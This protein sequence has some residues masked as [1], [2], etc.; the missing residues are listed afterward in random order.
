MQSTL[1][2]LAATLGPADMKLFV[3]AK[4]KLQTEGKKKPTFGEILAR[5]K[6]MKQFDK[7]GSAEKDKD[8]ED[9]ES[10]K[11]KPMLY[12]DEKSDKPE[13]ATVSPN[14]GPGF[15][16]R[17][18]IP[19]KAASLLAPLPLLPQSTA[20]SNL[21]RPLDR[22]PKTAADTSSVWS[23]L[24]DAGKGMINAGKE[25]VK[26]LYSA[27]HSWLSKPDNLATIL[28][29]LLLGGGGAAAG[30]LGS[31]LVDGSKRRGALL[32]GALGAGMGALAHKGGPSMWRPQMSPDTWLKENEQ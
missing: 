7:Q 10:K 11:R 27:G 3:E 14:N 26:D 25:G 23:S 24:G 5:M 18:M 6:I 1:E 8:S 19:A 16:A 21:L 30:A 20:V 22:L 17:P 31:H 9:K 28:R 29:M 4:K 32:G 12:G 2:K 13:G 15:T